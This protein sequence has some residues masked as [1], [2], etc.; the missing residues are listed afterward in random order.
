M[1]SSQE[2]IMVSTYLNKYIVQDEII[3]EVI[4]LKKVA[5]PKKVNKLKNTALY[6]VNMSVVLLNR[7]MFVVFV[8]GMCEVV[9]VV[10]RSM[11]PS[12]AG[13][14]SWGQEATPSSP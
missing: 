8:G 9:M 12:A 14:A 11:V 13:G 6:L 2:D 4:K 3:L 5:N 10:L 1:N 7:M